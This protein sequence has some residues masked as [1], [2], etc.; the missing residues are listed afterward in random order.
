MSTWLTEG[1]MEGRREAEKEG[2]RGERCRL[3]RVLAP[4]ASATRYRILHTL[5]DHSEN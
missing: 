5:L 4:I 2:R 1:K 3:D